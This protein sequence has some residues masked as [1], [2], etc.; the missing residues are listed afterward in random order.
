MWTNSPSL[1]N[2]I[3]GELGGNGIICDLAWSVASLSTPAN[4]VTKFVGRF[5]FSKLIRAP[6]LAFAAA[7]PQTEFTTTKVVPSFAIALSTASV[8]C[9]SSKPTFVKSARIGFTN[10]GG[11]IFFFFNYQISYGQLIINEIYA[12]VAVNLI[13]DA[14]GDEF[15]SAREDEF[16]ELF[17][18]ADTTV[19]ISDFEILVGGTNRHLFPDAT[20]MPAKT[21]IVLF[22]GGQPKGLFGGSPVVLASSG[23]LNL[24]NGGTTV[25]L[26]NKNGMSVDS[27]TYAE[28]NIDASLVRTPEFTGNFMPHTSRADAFGL[29][30]SPGTLTNSFPYNN[31]D[32]TLIHF[33][34][35]RGTAIERDANI[36]LFLNLI[37]PKP[38]AVTIRVE[39]TGGTGTAED[40]ANFV[41]QTINFPINSNS[42]R[43]LTI[44]ITDDD[45]VEGKETFIF[46]I[47][48]INAP[49]SNQV[50]INK[51][52]E[53]TLFDDDTD[54]GLLLTEYLADPPLGIDGDANGDGERSAS[55]DEF[56]EFFNTRDE[57]V[58]LSG[59]AIYD[60]DALR[61]QIP[62]GTIVQPN[63]F[64]L[65]FGGGT[66]GN[67]FDDAVVQKATTS[68][69]NLNNSSDRI[70]IRDSLNELVFFYEYGEEASGDQSLILCPIAS[71]GEYIKHLEAGG[72]ITPGT[73]H[74]CT[75][76]NVVSNVY[77]KAINIYPNPT[78]DFL[79]VDLPEHIELMEGM[80][81]RNNQGQQ[82]LS[83]SL[84]YLSVA[85]LPKGI[86]FLRLKT[87]KGLIVRKVLIN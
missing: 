2:A 81:L 54:F 62:E 22:G 86:Y 34:N 74:D 20:M 66:I 71:D 76:V 80:D 17:N 11:Y 39:L 77:E 18:Q 83:T 6:G 60:A 25:I 26:K 79:T 8:V 27:M 5:S 43:R 61:H 4:T 64:F 73:L 15:R 10:S 44:P 46:S 85:T 30:Y 28:N 21:F 53:L 32:T 69:L 49:D 78:N 59:M 72:L 29:P 1:N 57:P 40:L 50:S 7:Q 82:V 35:N 24:S 31:G 9:N 13:G 56:V 84:H 12:D 41:P 65:V 36:D 63:Q 19:D 48:S 3:L 37:N 68:R 38:A 58:D 67:D 23:N 42:Q 55:Q 75:I 45:I 33:T 51:S 16:I 47:T 70:I 87:S 52:F 14:N